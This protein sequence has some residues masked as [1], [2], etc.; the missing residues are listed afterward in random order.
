MN[1]TAEDSGLSN[2]I[3][4]KVKDR[5]RLDAVLGHGGYGG[6]YR[7]HGRFQYEIQ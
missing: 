2:A 6:V 7:A 1:N 4:W 5:F 3:G